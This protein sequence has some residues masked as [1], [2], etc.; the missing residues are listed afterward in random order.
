MNI[1]ATNALR[2]G[3]KSRGT[4]RRPESSYV[5]MVLFF[6]LFYYAHY[7]MCISSAPFVIFFFVVICLRAPSSFLIP[8]RIH[9]VRSRLA[10]ECVENRRTGYRLVDAGHLRL[11]VGIIK[12]ALDF[13][14]NLERQE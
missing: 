10:Q 3:K 11:Q 1:N 13:G 2:N 8:P 12:D 14:G 5:L 4:V 6:L 9:L 7:L